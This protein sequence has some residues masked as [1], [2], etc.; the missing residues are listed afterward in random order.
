MCTD[1]FSTKPQ[2]ALVTTNFAQNIHMY[3]HIRTQI[4]DSQGGAVA[5]NHVEA[6]KE[7]RGERRRARGAA[8]FFFEHRKQE[9]KGHY[10][11]ADKKKEN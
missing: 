4:C 11:S 6:K 9:K 1:A 10:Q 5:R 2:K 3:T 8:L 7:K